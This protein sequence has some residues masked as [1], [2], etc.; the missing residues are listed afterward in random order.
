MPSHRFPDD[1]ANDDTLHAA[2]HVPGPITVHGPGPEG[3][4]PFDDAMLRYD[5][6]G[7][8]FGMS[9]DAGM[10]WDPEETR[11]PQFVI[12]STLGGL[13][14]PDG[15]PIALG[16]HTGHFE[17]DEAVAVA[18]RE[19]RN[20]GG[21]PYAGYCSDP[22]DGRTQGTPGMFDS[23][24]YRNDAAII[25]RRLARSIPN[26]V[27]VIG[28]ATCDKGLPAMMMALA[29]LRELPVVIVPGGVM[30]PTT[31][32]EDTGKVQSIGAR[33]AQG[34]ITLEDAQ[35][36]ACHTCASPG[37]GCQ[38]L[39]TAATSQ[40]VAEALGLALPHSALAPSGQP[41][42]HDIARRSAQALTQ[43]VKKG[44][45]GKAI[46]TEAA[47][48]NAMVLHAA[49]GGSTNLILHLP[50]VLY[51]AGLPRPRLEDWE[52]VNRQ[53]PR[54]V[55][56]LPNG[57]NNYPTLYVYLAGGV[58][59][60]M[61]HLR[62]LGLLRLDALTVTGH[63]VGEVLEWW[64]NSPRR[65]HLR[66]VLRQEAG[67]EPDQVI[68]SPSRAAESGMTG[69]SCFPRGNLA[70]GGSVVK[71]TAIDPR[72]LDKNGVF[73]RVLRARVFVREKDAVAAIKGQGSDPVRPGDAVVLIGRGPMGSGMEETYQVTSALRYLPWGHEVAVITDARFSGVSTGACIGWVTPEALAGGP[74]SRVR[75][76]DRVRI[77]IDT[78]NLRGSV[79]LVGDS[80]K[81]LSP[82]EAE[83]VLTERL[84]HPELRPDEDLPEDTRLWA[85]LQHI[86]GGPW[87]GCV[88][89]REAI[90]RCLRPS[91]D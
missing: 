83:K 51:E 10:G 8:L 80:E 70:P 5:P 62:D 40:V 69:T 50:A 17:L 35:D 36:V 38:F 55:D 2:D 84:P 12:L 85:M 75:D 4:L 52:R 63:T 26:A 86:S 24:P 73:D 64:E 3:R 22:C 29:G 61:L 13:R 25:F 88:F 89:D 45:S 31:R 78:R 68:L 6:S 74:V 18:A 54:L 37:G 57:P 47:A 34:E 67:V 76:G 16:Y 19:I 32:G 30:L 66:E 23:L 39:G 90:L 82:E 81:D 65:H 91:Q 71:S 46:L 1:R 48:H 41:I 79:D 56:V 28:I 44:I 43:L 53:V 9:Q 27:G 33:Y 87:A 49:F 21:M 59:E 11:R 20:L 15:K 7:H 14:D 60:V 77:V 42:W 58:P 72:V